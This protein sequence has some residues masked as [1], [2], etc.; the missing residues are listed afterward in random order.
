MTALV[1]SKPAQRVPAVQPNTAIAVMQLIERA[2]L[3][4]N[5][6][7]EKMESLMKMKERFDAAEAR[8]EF[9]R[10]LADFKAEAPSVKKKKQVK[11]TTSHGSTQYK[12]A[13]LGDTVKI[14]V[15]HLSK[16]GFSHAWKTD[17]K[18]GKM[19]VTC[20]LTHVLGHSESVT[21]EAPYDASGGKNAIQ[22]IVSAKSYLERHTFMAVTGLAAQDEDDDGKGAGKV[23]E[24]PKIQDPKESKKSGKPEAAKKEPEPPAPTKGTDTFAVKIPFLF[25]VPPKLEFRGPS[26]HQK[27]R[28]EPAAAKTAKAN[29]KDGDTAIVSWELKDNIKHATNIDR[30][31]SDPSQFDA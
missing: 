31:A 30:K 28:V 27:Y 15:P 8:K 6:N 4:P 18:D 24:P 14:I 17:Q 23:E 13:T 20:V 2:V 22:A 3:D 29:F 5:F 11:F 9:V 26:P 10:A 16:F 21:L 25:G 7:V 1:K 19:A 12:H